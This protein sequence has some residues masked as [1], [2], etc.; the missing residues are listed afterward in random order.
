M[1]PS[2]Y[3]LTVYHIW[4]DNTIICREKH[5]KIPEDGLIYGYK[6]NRRGHTMAYN[7]EYFA[8]TREYFGGGEERNTGKYIREYGATQ[9]PDKRSEN[10]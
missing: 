7:F 6:Q 5:I 9:T 3:V 4:R 1:P 2:S 10:R 8:P